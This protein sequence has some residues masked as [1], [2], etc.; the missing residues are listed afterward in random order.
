METFDEA[1][2]RLRSERGLSLD[3]LGK[4]AHITRGYAHQLEH[5]ARR[6]SEQTAKLL[7]KA[8]DADGL[9][10]TAAARAGDMTNAPPLG[11]LWLP[12]DAEGLAASL[13]AERPNADNATRLAHQWLI[14]EPPQSLALTAGRRIG[15][16]V[17]KATVDRIHQIRLIDDYAGGRDTYATARFELEATAKLLREASYSDEVGRLLLGAV[18]ELAQ[19]VGWIASDAG[20]HGEARRLYLAGV[21]AGHAAGDGPG[22]ASNLSSLA[23]QE[24][25]VGDPAEAVCLAR[26]AVRGAAGATATSRALLLER[27]AWAQARS[28]NA[29]GAGRALDLV[30]DAFDHRDPAADPI[31][32]YW[33]NRDEIDVMAGRVWTQLRRPL[34]AVPLLDRAIAAYPVDAA[35]EVSLYRTWLAEALLQGGEIERAEAELGRAVDLADGAGSDRSD[36]RVQEIRRQIDAAKAA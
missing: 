18:A 27:L 21:R 6:P 12:G 20:R 36:V 33:L 19:I 2:R 25:N 14:T 23:Y 13:L 3:A 8:L 16:S 29:D 4:R 5:G 10:I 32:V 31:W 11:E 26:S 7:D 15:T 35:R 9:L 34:R 28:G 24:A 22:A 1:L 30:D 17:V